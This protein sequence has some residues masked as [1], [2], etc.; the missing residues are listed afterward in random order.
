MSASMRKMQACMCVYVCMCICMH[1]CM[2]ACMYGCIHAC[3]H[4]CMHVCV[5]VCMYECMH[6]CMHVCVYVYMY[7]SPGLFGLPDSYMRRACTRHPYA[8]RGRVARPFGG[9]NIVFAGDLWQL[10][11]VR[12]N[13]I[14]SNPFKTG[15]SLTEQRMHDLLGC[16]KERE[17]RY[18]GRRTRLLQRHLPEGGSRVP[19]VVG[20]V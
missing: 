15:Y 10:P 1:E 14:F 4:D 16:E 20:A 8:R 18:E 7:V 9:L 12:A 17:E 19:H 5:Y 2:H 13:T 6:T 11:P 3:M